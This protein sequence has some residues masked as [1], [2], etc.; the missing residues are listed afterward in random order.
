[1]RFFS[2]FYDIKEL[3][4]F[5]QFYSDRFFSLL[6]A[7]QVMHIWL[8]H[9]WRDCNKC[10]VN[11][12]RNTFLITKQHIVPTPCFCALVYGMNLS[13][14]LWPN[15]QITEI[16]H[17]RP[18]LIFF[19]VNLVLTFCNL[20][21][22]A[23][24]LFSD[25]FPRERVHDVDFCITLPSLICLEQ[26]G[27]FFFWRSGL[28]RNKPTWIVNNLS[29]HWLHARFTSSYRII[30]QGV[31]CVARNVESNSFADKHKFLN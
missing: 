14:F 29:P 10:L 9:C 27:L 2:F 30:T 24:L 11:T 4:I 17:Q 5:S 6:Q 31:N 28:R 1:M 25:F 21:V 8:V 22:N 15:S 20:R 26:A 19:S 16:V 12:F 18:A 13:A 23:A 7:V 3:H